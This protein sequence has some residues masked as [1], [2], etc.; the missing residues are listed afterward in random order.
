MCHTSSVSDFLQ[1]ILEEEIIF[2]HREEDSVMPDFILP[3]HLPRGSEF[4]T[5]V[6]RPEIDTNA[7]LYRLLDL[8]SMQVTNWHDI[9][10]FIASTLSGFASYGVRWYVG[11]CERRYRSLI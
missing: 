10:I 3:K 8:M 2:R 6:K 4:R 1:P 5:T 11:H 9:N 7:H